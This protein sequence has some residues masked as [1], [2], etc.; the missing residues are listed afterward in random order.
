M[1]RIVKK[2]KGVLYVQN[3]KV[4]KAS[5]R[6]GIVINLKCTEEICDAT[7][8]NE[9]ESFEILVN[10]IQGRLSLSFDLLQVKIHPWH[11]INDIIK[12]SYLIFSIYVWH[13]F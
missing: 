5:K 1:V 8:R 7:A 4:Y 12:T 11:K 10:F 2:G 6:R 9:G 13:L 3:S